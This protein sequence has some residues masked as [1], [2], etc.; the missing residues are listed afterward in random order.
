MTKSG[1]FLFLLLFI[2]SSSSLSGQN[3]KRK[4]RI[5]N[6]FNASLIMGMNL[7]QINGDNSTGFDKI[8]LY[9]GVRGSVILSHRAQLNVELLY[10]Q[11]GSRIERRNIITGN[12]KEGDEFIK[13]D[14][15][16]VPFLL[17]LF[18]KKDDTG[19][20][21]ELGGAYARLF[22]Q[23]IEQKTLNPFRGDID[24][25][26]KVDTFNTNEFSL[27][28]GLG[29]DFAKHYSLGMRYAFGVTDLFPGDPTHAECAKSMSN[30][31]LSFLVAYNFK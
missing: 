29:F 18:T 26:K 12:I 22:R 13:V 28:A 17:K 5:T 19:F 15:M 9:G 7:S 2:I 24:F 4:K 8:G 1:Y 6:R 16:E 3:R 30:Y 11:K 23:R 25:S 21:V 27:L 20:Y 10:S 14:Y 31:F